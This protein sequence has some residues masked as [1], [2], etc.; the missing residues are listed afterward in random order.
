MTCI[1]GTG[2]T[3]GGPDAALP[4]LPAWSAAEKESDVTEAIAVA[5][6]W[7]ED[8]GAEAAGN[9]DMET[10]VMGWRER[11]RTAWDMECNAAANGPHRSCLFLY[12]RALL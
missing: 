5:G 8:G 2:G 11:E 12:T 10:A 9:G 7:G 1:T 4:V 6:G 3:A